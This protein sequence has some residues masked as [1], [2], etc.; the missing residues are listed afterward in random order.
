MSSQLAHRP[1]EEAWRPEKPGQGAER[2]LALALADF[3]RPSERGAVAVRSNEDCVTR[4]V[5]SAARNITNGSQPG[6]GSLEE[7]AVW[8]DHEPRGKGVVVK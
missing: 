7:M 5:V 6:V 2:R 4:P 3:R 1:A 8:L